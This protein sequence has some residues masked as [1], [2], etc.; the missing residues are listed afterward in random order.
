MFFQLLLA[1]HPETLGRKMVSI[2]RTGVKTRIL[3]RRK[4]LFRSAA[5][6]LLLLLVPIGYFA[7]V[8]GN[9]GPLPAFNQPDATSSLD[10][11]TMYTSAVQNASF[12]QSVVAALEQEVYGDQNGDGVVN[13]A[14]VVVGMQIAS[15][16]V[17]PTSIQIALNNLKNDD[18]IDAADAMITLQHIASAAASLDKLR[19]VTIQDAEGTVGDDDPI[20][21]EVTLNDMTSGASGFD[22]M[23]SIENASKATINQVKHPNY[24]FPPPP[25]LISPLTPSSTVKIRVVDF[26]DI[27]SGPFSRQVIATLE[28]ELLSD[29]ETQIVVGLIR[30]DGPNPDGFNLVPGTIRQN[31]T[32]VVN[33]APQ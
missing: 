5:S 27:L 15:D 20:T 31:G 26:N 16:G 14:D 8:Q 17:E 7:T 12:S 19:T 11:T 33:A 13:I 23:I 32:L 22:L 30:L 10:L 18:T 6:A 1:A 21:L 29:G 2:I 9:N 3:L 4:W 24:G 28:V 25:P